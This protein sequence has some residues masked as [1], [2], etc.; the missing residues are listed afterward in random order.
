MSPEGERRVRISKTVKIALTPEAPIIGVF[1]I[2]IR[3]TRSATE[4]NL[5]NDQV[6]KRRRTFAGFY[7]DKPVKL[8]K[9]KKR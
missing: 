4:E 1:G 6:A 7:R 8:D 3:H 2:K 9:H 5:Y